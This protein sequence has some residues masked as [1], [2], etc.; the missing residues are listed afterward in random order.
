M[1]A[2]LLDS[3]APE[4]TEVFGTRKNF[5]TAAKCVGRQSLRKKF[6]GGSW[7]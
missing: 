6:V 5:K 2:G 4:I 3:A 7:E 1:C